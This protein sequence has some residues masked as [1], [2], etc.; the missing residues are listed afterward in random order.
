MGGLI[1]IGNR[2]F[3]NLKF[4]TALLIFSL[5]KLFLYYLLG[6]IS[7]NFLALVLLTR[8]TA[9]RYIVIML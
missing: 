3:L 9:L 1:L 4:E 7:E 5:A 6:L 2:I 8:N